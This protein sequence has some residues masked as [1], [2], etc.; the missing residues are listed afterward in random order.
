MH[1]FFRS[2]PYDDTKR[3]NKK[4]DNT[5][6]TKPF[7]ISGPMEYF[8]KNPYFTDDIKPPYKKIIKK[9][10]EGAPFVPPSRINNVS[11]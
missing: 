8:D 10:F 4:K 11:S 3:T 5:T 6:I 7:L 9:K 2:S 1:I